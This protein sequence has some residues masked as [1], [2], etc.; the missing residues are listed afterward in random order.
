MSRTQS[1]TL[2]NMCMVCDGKG[3]VLV[4]DRNDEHWGGISFPGGHIEHGES[5]TDSVIREIKEE[6]GLT[7]SEPK[8]C[9]IKDWFRP[10]GSRYIVFCY[11][12]DKFSG[13]LRSSEEGE[14][15]WASLDGLESMKLA[16]SMDMMI[17][18]F[19]DEN[20]SEMFREKDMWELI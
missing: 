15:F 6:T 3:N 19:T 17:K 18:V 8:L 16:V 14:I 13:K 7:V 1:V 5:V 20:V 12:A 9:G 4:Q 10:D 2:T 11:R